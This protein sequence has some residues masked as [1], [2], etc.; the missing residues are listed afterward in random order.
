MW[1][2][3]TMQYY[4]VVAQNNKMINYPLVSVVLDDNGKIQSVGNLE[5]NCWLNSSQNGY[6]ISNS[7]LEEKTISK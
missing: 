2:F 5:Q 7:L 4:G 3:Q 6:T 1:C